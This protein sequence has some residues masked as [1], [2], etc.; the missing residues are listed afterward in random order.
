MKLSWR[1]DRSV[2]RRAFHHEG[3]EEVKCVSG[4]RFRGHITRGNKTE[5]ILTNTENED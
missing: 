3:D 4:D 1:R 2:R 5:Q